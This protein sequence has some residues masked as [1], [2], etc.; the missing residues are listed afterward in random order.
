LDIGLAVMQHLFEPLPG[1]AAPAE[2]IVPVYLDRLF[3]GV[4]PVRKTLSQKDSTPAFRLED[5]AGMLC[6]YWL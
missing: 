3:L 5:I 2:I 6:R 4:V 1:V